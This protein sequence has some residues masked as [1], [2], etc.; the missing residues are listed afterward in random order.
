MREYRHYTCDECHHWI[1]IK[2]DSMLPDEKDEHF[3]KYGHEAV[4]CSRYKPA[5]EVQFS[6][7]YSIDGI[8]I[9]SGL[10][11]IFFQIEILNPED[12][13]FLS[14]Q[15][16]FTW[17]E[18][19]RFIDL[20]K[21]RTIEDALKLWKQRF[22][23]YSIKNFDD[24][25]VISIEKNEYLI[26]NLTN[27]EMYNYHILVRPSSRINGNEPW[28]TKHFYLVLLDENKHDIIQSNNYYEILIIFK[29][30]NE[31][32]CFSRTRVE[33]WW[34]NMFGKTFYTRIDDTWC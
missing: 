24:K 4:E 3:C 8:S 13:L 25:K 6:I 34:L 32:K 11:E 5:D 27:S 30:L 2:S 29:L 23:K 15:R 9:E 31:I 10:T 7:K 12:K 18:T 19:L 28:F 33:E 16:I 17:D 21:Y 20:F 22:F 26:K 1:I 14:S